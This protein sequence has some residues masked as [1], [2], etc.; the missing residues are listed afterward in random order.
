MYHL[1]T[2]IYLL[3]IKYFFVKRKELVELRQVNLPSY[4]A[5]S[6]DV[7]N[8]KVEKKNPLESKRAIELDQKLEKLYSSM[9]AN[10]GLLDDSYLIS[11][12]III[13]L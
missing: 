2:I 11:Y 3:E 5:D 12:E 4:L 10:N 9:D 7:Q 1:N 8:G 6:L 13:H